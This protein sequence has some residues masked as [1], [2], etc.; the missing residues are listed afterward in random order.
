MLYEVITTPGREDQ[1]VVHAEV[2]QAEVVLGDRRE[3][4]QVRAVVGADQRGD[5]HQ[6]GA[7]SQRTVSLRIT[8]YNVCYTKLLREFELE[9]RR[10]VANRARALSRIELLVGRDLP[11]YNFV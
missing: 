9:H 3:Q 8:S 4:R 11:S 7:G 10:A 6:C 2:L 5:D 1:A